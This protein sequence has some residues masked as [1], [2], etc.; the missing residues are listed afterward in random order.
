MN[1]PDY[2]RC[3]RCGYLTF[4]VLE[5]SPCGHDDPPVRASLDATGTVYSWTRVWETPESGSLMAMAD[6]FDG[7]LRITAPVRDAG[8]IAIGDEVLAVSGTDTLVALV[9]R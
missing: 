6:F 2:G 3:P 8:E 9:R 5:L 7:A 1:H 4:P